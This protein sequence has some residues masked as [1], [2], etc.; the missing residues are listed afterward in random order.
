MKMK[1]ISMVALALAFVSCSNEDEL[2]QPTQSLKDTP[3][4]VDVAIADMQT[5][6]GFDAD[7][8]LERFYMD[9]I[10]PDNGKYDY[11]V[12]MKKE[13]NQWASYDYEGHYTEQLL[14]AGDGKKVNVTAATF[15]M[16]NNP[17]ELAVKTDQ[18]SAENIKAS[19]HLFMPTTSVTPSADG[20][21]VVL[22]HLMSKIKL[23]IELKDEF[24]ATT[25]P[26]SKVSICGTLPMRTY[27][28]YAGTEDVSPWKDDS[29]DGF[30][31]TTAVISPYFNI[32][33]TAKGESRAYGE[34]EAILV[35]QTVAPNDFVIL[36]NVGDRLFRWAYTGELTLE[37][38]MEYTLTLIAGHDKVRPVSFNAKGWNTDGNNSTI[39]GKTE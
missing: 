8:Q 34:F 18:S 10:H 11:W 29:D 9:V 31:V 15:L 38:G 27:N 22:N 3:I 16:N 20:I 4:K 2:I 5:R 21:K 28:L 37:G 25:N 6:A 17:I 23:V 33:E 35:P 39:T 32:F 13:R 36:F 24:D 12:M 19:D 14:W 30:F 1:M 7:D 26:F